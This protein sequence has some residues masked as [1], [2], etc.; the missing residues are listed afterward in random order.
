M[1]ADE[2]VDAPVLIRLR[3]RLHRAIRLAVGLAFVH[4]AKPHERADAIR[5]QAEDGMAATEQ[6]D[7]LGARL[8]DTRKPR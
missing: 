3:E 4:Q 2:P 6:Q 8:A 7:L 5:L 1:R